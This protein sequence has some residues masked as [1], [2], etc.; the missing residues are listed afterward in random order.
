MKGLTPAQA[1]RLATALTGLWARKLKPANMRASAIVF[2]P[3]QDDETL[4]CGG[5]ILKKRRLGASVQ[6]VYLSD[7]CTS[8]PSLPAHEVRTL[9]KQEAHAAC[10]QLGVAPENVTFFGLPD[11]QL[12]EEK[13]HAIERVARYL[14]EHPAQQV[15]IPYHEDRDPCLDHVATNEIVQSALR[16]LGS[17]QREHRVRVDLRNAPIVRLVV[18]IDPGCCKSQLLEKT[19]FVLRDRTGT[20][21]HWICK[22]IG[23]R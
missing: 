1:R 13:G 10:R 15:Y 21:G 5:T 17:E 3:H 6:I 16:R 7:G 18:P 22:S 8:P 14:H 11:G 9:R 2:S 12:T 23:L 20:G 19:V 4:G